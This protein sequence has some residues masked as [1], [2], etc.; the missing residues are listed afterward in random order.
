MAIS[1]SKIGEAFV[2]LVV[3][4]NPLTRG[5]KTA[6][7]Q[8]SR[9]GSGMQSA[10]RSAVGAGGSMV[11]TAAAMAAP[12]ILAMR[13]GMKFQ[14]VMSKVGAISQ[15]SGE[16]LESLTNTAKEL[17]R[18]TSFSASQV[19]E[20]MAELGRKG[21]SPEQ[22][23]AAIPAVMNLARATDT[24]LALA[25]TVAGAAL[26]QFGLDADQTES[27]ANAMTTTANSTATSVESLGESLKYAGP[28]ANDLGMSLEETL[29][30]IGALGDVGIDGSAAGTA[31][32]RLST[33]TAAEADKIG[34]IF[35]RNFV[36]ENGDALGVIETLSM[37]DEATKGMG[38]AERMKKMND[39][40]GLLGITGASVI[41]KKGEGIAAI[42][43]KIKAGQASGSA[44]TTATA[45]DDNTGGSFRMLMSAIEGVAIAIHDALAPAFRVVADGASRVAG[46]ITGLVESNGQ[47]VFQVVAGIA[48]FGAF[49]LGMIAAGVAIGAVGLAVSGIATGIGLLMS[50][51][52]LAMRA[53][54]KD[55]I[56]KHPTT[57]LDS[58]WEPHDPPPSTDQY[59]RQS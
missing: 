19:A 36:D 37:I 50:P 13:S 30:I 16:Q 7:R 54:G 24:E 40:F 20:G 29:A 48:A 44:Q 58:Y 57:S 59:F 5:L 4:R 3:D 12:F 6:R 46:I 51:I 43:E 32:K 42:L 10:G 31:L 41:G 25:A 27:V 2:S 26:K 45:M 52:G 17:G 33:V 49:G 8:L 53:M 9:F 35:G 1:R 18:T 55:P 47:L 11:G 14:D 38:S 39:A 56:S 28:I 15:A 22:I 34:A 21:F 23:E